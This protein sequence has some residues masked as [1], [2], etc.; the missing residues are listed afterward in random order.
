MRLTEKKR[1]KIDSE[2]RDYPIYLCWINS[3]GGVSYWLF[4]KQHT[5]STKTRAGTTYVKNISDLE[6]AKGNLD[7]VG[8]DSVH[9]FKVG[10][11]LKEEDMDGIT[12]LYE[13][14]KVMR[15][16]NPETWQTDGCKWQNVLIKTGS[17]L[18]LN[19]GTAFID[20]KFD[21]QMPFIYTQKE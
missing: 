2:C 15:L 17:L 21:I 13:S 9:S 14:P 5:E 1:I 6:T 3:L 12:G 20:V 16:M 8:K 11:R 7:I 19:T 18:I 4:S 10:A